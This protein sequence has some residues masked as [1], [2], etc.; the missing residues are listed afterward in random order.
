MLQPLSSND[1]FFLVTPSLLFAS[2]DAAVD[3]A[4]DPVVGLVLVAGLQIS[5][6]NAEMYID[7][8]CWIFY[9]FVSLTFVKG[10]QYL[11]I[12]QVTLPLSYPL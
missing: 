12:R 7:F 6:S 8:F 4:D 9:L 10:F 5:K 3:S 2:E 11:S 1:R